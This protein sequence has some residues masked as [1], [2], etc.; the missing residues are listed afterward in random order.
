MVYIYKHIQF[1][2][3]HTRMLDLYLRWL[4]LYMRF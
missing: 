3:Y 2:I 1:K 4:Y